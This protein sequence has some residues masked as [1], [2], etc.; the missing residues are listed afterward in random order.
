MNISPAIIIDVALIAVIVVSVFHYARKGFVAGLMDLVGNLASL[1]LA[2]VVSGKLSPTVFE[3]FFKS[4]F[5]E[6]TARTIQQQGGVNLSVIL[7]GLS[8]ILPQK[9]IDDIT[10]SAAGMLDSGAPDIAQQV[11][12]KI[13]APLV[14]PLI[15]VVVFF[16]TF[17][18]CRVVIA[19]LV[20]V[21]TNINKIPLL[22]GVNRILGVCIGVV[23]GFINVLLILCLLWAVVVITNG[24]LP[25]VNDSSLSGSC[26]Y[27]FFSA[28]NPFL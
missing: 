7:D 19:F 28:Y 14:V 1:A 23:A 27:S 26:F 9:F 11:V 8:G 10:A 16:A 4:G 5:I 2:W 21:L 20:T 25:F 22:G 18:L 15:T 13:I 3:N 17:V 12:E 6:Q 24:N